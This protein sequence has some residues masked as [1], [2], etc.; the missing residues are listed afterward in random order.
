VGLNE[1]IP[2]NLFQTVAEVLAYVYSIKR[3]KG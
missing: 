2:E 3:K 1:T